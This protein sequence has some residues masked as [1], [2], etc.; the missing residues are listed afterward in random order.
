MDV[1]W[2]GSAGARGFDGD[3]LARP[4]WS[5]G[6]CWSCGER[7]D[8]EGGF[9]CFYG[10][11]HPVRCVVHVV[12]ATAVIHDLD[13]EHDHHHYDDPA[14][15]C[16]DHDDGASAASAAHLC[17]RGEPRGVRHAKADA[18]EQEPHSGESGAVRRVA[19][20]GRLLRLAGQ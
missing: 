5:S 13:V 1:G 19:C 4:C 20:A 11:N 9:C 2:V 10:V 17:H 8:A 16:D 15:S 18:G 3:R 14:P 6:A 12:P 7:R